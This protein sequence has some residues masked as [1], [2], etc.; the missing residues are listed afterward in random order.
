MKFFCLSVLCALLIP[1]N[2][3]VAQVRQ[4][5]L[6][7]IVQASSIICVATATDV[8]SIADRNGEVV[9]I[10]TFRLEE[11]IT[12]KPAKVFKIKQLGGE[13]KGI[14]HRLEHIRYF[15]KGERVLLTLYPNS[16]LGF[17]NP[18]GLNQG[19]WTVDVFNRVVGVTP[20]Q[21][22]DVKDVLPDYA[23]QYSTQPQTIEKKQFVS[24][25]KHLSAARSQKGVAR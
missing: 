12:G 16:T 8:R 3:S 15:R 25:L 22:Q 13:Y 11:T 20:T 23:I 6:P 10:T 14:S 4:L 9:T 1:Y 5:G 24:L 17:T 7:E 19:V 21:L 18:V 2:V